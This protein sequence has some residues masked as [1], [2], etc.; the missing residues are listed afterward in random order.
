M[1]G[2][3]ATPS[4]AGL[5]GVTSYTFQGTGVSGTTLRYSWDLGDGVTASGQTATHTY[6]QAGA[7]TVRLT[8]SNSAGAASQTIPVTVKSLTGRWEVQYNG[9]FGERGTFDLVQTGRRIDGNYVSPDIPDA[10]IEAS[11]II[12]RNIRIRAF[13]TRRNLSMTFDGNLHASGDKVCGT[14]NSV[15]SFVMRR[16]GSSEQFNNDCR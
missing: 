8:V 12:G 1:S 10:I 16:T 7:F 9:G 2:I 4:E 14:Y 13:S 3:F 6:Q 11:D 15:S 5:A